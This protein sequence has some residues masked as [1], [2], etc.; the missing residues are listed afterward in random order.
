M[1]SKMVMKRVSVAQGVEHAIEVHGADVAAGLAERLDRELRDGE[2][3]PDWEFVLELI[4]RAIASEREELLAIDRAH[5]DELADDIEPKLRLKKLTQE[6]YRRVIEFRR[7]FDDAFKAPG[8][9]IFGIKGRTPK[10]PHP[11]SGLVEQILR[12]LQDPGLELPR[13]RT[14]FTVDLPFWT[15]RFEKI[16]KKLDQALADTTREKPQSHLTM[17]N[18]HRG[19]K[20][21]DR[22]FG[23]V[24][25]L[26][27]A[28]FELAGFKA[29]AR[30]LHPKIYR[31]DR[32]RKRK[33]A[34]KAAQAASQ[35]RTG[36]SPANEP[37]AGA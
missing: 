30:K 34:K 1:P 7:G 13:K 15:K 37:P 23:P 4:R 2:E 5:L 33:E 16:F 3:A 27:E 32:I 9:K 10:D 22:F 12:R 29:W 6:A 8:I 14:G 28:A 35:A 20:G 25:R 24:A 36:D 17:A 11:L 26:L 18:R 21:F 31:P 19:L